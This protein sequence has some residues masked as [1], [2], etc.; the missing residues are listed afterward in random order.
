MTAI[1]LHESEASVVMFDLRGFS[2]LATTLGPIELGVALN[3]FYQ[4]AED[5]VVAHGGRM[6]KLIGDAV[7]AVWLENEARDHRRQAVAAVQQGTATKAAWAK[8]NQVLGALDY[9]IAAATGRVLAGELGTARVHGFD[10]LGAP[11]S[12][13]AKLTTLATVRG[14]DNLVT[15]ETL[16]SPAGRIA[17]IEVEGAELGGRQLRLFRV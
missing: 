3:R 13:A 1:L 16:D 10:V 11:V 14:V 17:A 4:H 15:S 2:Q 12:L 8:H 5:C 6:L 9:S 7:V